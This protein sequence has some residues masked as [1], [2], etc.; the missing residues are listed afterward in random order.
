MLIHTGVVPE[1]VTKSL[2]GK[3]ERVD[4]IYYRYVGPNRK[5][6]PFKQSHFRKVEN[7]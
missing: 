4:R 5:P 6:V 7:K 1:V 2:D 3:R